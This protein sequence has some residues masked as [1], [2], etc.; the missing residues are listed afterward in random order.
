MHETDALEED[1][2]DWCHLRKHASSQN[3][4][5]ETV[6]ELGLLLFVYVHSLRQATFL[7]HLYARTDLAPCF[8]ALDYT[9]YARWIQIHIR[10]MAKLAIEHPDVSYAIK[11][12]QFHCA[13]DE[14]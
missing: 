12:L 14:K 9:N 11:C 8:R 10:G 5:W 7:M 1:F 2:E 3:Q 13:E 6:L 4:Y